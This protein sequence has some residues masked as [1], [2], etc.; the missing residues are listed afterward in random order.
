M[1]ADEF[2]DGAEWYLTV[3][4][5]DSMFCAWLLQIHGESAKMIV[6]RAQAVSRTAHPV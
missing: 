4:C 6:G 2:G 5:A 1:V 3:R